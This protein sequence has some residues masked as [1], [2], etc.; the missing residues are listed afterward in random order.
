MAISP[1]RS[2]S[3][4]EAPSPGVANNAVQASVASAG[5]RLAA[6]P[7]AVGSSTTAARMDFTR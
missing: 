6:S 4:T 5:S 7:A 2:V 1:L 3:A